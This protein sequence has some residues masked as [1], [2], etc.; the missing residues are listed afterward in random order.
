[1][2]MNADWDIILALKIAYIKRDTKNYIQKGLVSVYRK[3]SNVMP[4]V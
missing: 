2:P 3:Y 1:M 4:Y